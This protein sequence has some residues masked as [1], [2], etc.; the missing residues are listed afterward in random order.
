MIAGILGSSL[1]PDGWNWGVLLI[2]L[3][4]LVLGSGFFF[5]KINP[6][7]SRNLSGILS[8][9]L[10]AGFGGFISDLN[11]Q[12]HKPDHFTHSQAGIQAFSG[13]ISSDHSDR[14]NYIRYEFEIASLLTDSTEVGSRGTIYLYLKKGETIHVLPYGTVLWIKS[15]IFD[16]EPPGNP[17]EF[18]YKEYLSGKNIFGQVFVS[19]NDI[20]IVGLNPGN[21]LLGYAYKIRA[22]ASDL[23][24]ASIP[25]HQEAA[26]LNALLIGVKDYLDNEIKSAY[27]EAGAMHVLA[28]S[29]LHVG[30]IYLLVVVALGFMRNKKWGRIMFLTIALMV[31][32]GYA[33]VT[34]FSPSVM[35]AATMFS[36]ILISD[37]I[38]RKSNI[39]NSLGLAAFILLLYDPNL[40][41]DVGFQLSFAAVFGIVM[42]Q[43]SLAGIWKPS[44]KVV[45][46]L[47]AI[48][49]VSIAAQ[50]ATFPLAVFYFHQLPVYFLVSNLIIIPSAMVML[51]SGMFMLLVASIS[52]TAGQV[53]GFLVSTF[54][55][56]VNH[57]ILLIKELPL[58]SMDWLYLTNVE[59]LLIYIFMVYMVSGLSTHRAGFISFSLLSLI[60]LFS[61][62]HILRWENG[63][64]SHLIV[65][66]LNEGIAIDLIDNGEAILLTDRMDS[67][68]I[69]D[70]EYKVNPNRLANGLPPYMDSVATFDQ[71][72]L[73]ETIDKLSLLHWKE[74]RVAILF[75]D[76]AYS[77]KEKV[78]TDLL[79]TNSSSAKLISMIQA[80]Q[81]IISGEDY[82]Q[83]QETIQQLT[84]SGSKFH[85]LSGDGYFKMDLKNAQGF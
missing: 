72:P 29:G 12:L 31:I 52:T 34:G 81:F 76:L 10:I 9:L 55:G 47:W 67:T 54:V 7:V 64:K 83:K 30:I 27:S 42:M 70:L 15:R 19:E 79:I 6:E 16:I 58:A 14:G 33:L 2:V 51:T 46:Y 49:T 32:W 24:S 80:D 28:V 38:G 4:I 63:K 56:W 22:Q 11:N 59:V 37:N 53:I 62:D 39:Y 23:I 73:I 75:G 69:K 1:T 36:I 57:L 78:Q 44:N 21:Q 40:L 60:V 41:Y 43:P 61:I 5:R 25:G 18:N 68:R 85:D 13:R 71:F 20:R 84:S 65:Y 35:R 77:L 48:I 45:N 50:I 8:L 82:Y 74:K 66:H 17:H 3:F 26:V